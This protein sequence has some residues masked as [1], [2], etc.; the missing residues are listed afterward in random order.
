MFIIAGGG[1]TKENARD[2]KNKV[3][4]ITEDGL[5]WGCYSQQDHIDFRLWFN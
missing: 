2:Q 1:Q 5:G 4:V 3:T